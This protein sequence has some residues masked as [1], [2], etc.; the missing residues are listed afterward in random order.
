[1]GKR[2]GEHRLMR[3]SFIQSASKTSTQPTSITPLYSFEHADDYVYDVKWSPSHP[4]LFGSV[5]GD[6]RFDLWNLNTDTEEPAV[7][8]LVGSGRALN[9]LAWDKEGKRTVV[10]SSD[11]R[12]YVYDIGEVSH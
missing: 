10:G 5:D 2:A 6:G 8:T 11:G 3:E 4:A 7:S 12:A 9:K 1:M